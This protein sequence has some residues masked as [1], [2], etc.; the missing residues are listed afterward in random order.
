MLATVA[1]APRIKP[2]ADYIIGGSAYSSPTQWAPLPVSPRVCRNLEEARTMKNVPTG[3]NTSNLIFHWTETNRAVVFAFE[4]V[5]HNFDTRCA[6][7]RKWL[8][9]AI[10]TQTADNI[11]F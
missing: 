10:R 9:L 8:T 11:S 3:R 7:W 6:H 4:A 5:Y 2:V 1:I